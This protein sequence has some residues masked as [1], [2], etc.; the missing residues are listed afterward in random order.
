MDIILAEIKNFMA[1][2]DFVHLDKVPVG[3]FRTEVVLK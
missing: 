1:K 2:I 3:K